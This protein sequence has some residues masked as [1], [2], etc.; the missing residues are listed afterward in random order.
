MQSK[1]L[2]ITAA[3]TLS[4]VLSQAQAQTLPPPPVSPVPVVNFEY[5]AQGNPTRSVAAPSVPA[6]NLQTTT[7][8]D[9]LD[10]PVE[11]TDPR[12]GKTQL[13][14]NGQDRLTQVTDPRNLVTQTPRDGLGNPLKL[15]SPDTG[16]AVHTFDLNGNLATRID[17]RGVK[18]VYT[19]DVLD[20]LTQTVYSQTGQTSL[21][22]TQTYDQTGAGY[23][24]GIG[25]LTSTNSP[26]A[27]SQYLYNE[28][29]WVITE[30]QR[31]KANAAANPAQISKT[32]VYTY[33]GAGVIT[34]ITYPSGRKLSINTVQG[35][36]QSLSLSNTTAAAAAT[37]IL[38]GIQWEPFGPPSNW[39]WPTATGAQPNP[40]IYDLSGRMVRYRLANTVRD[41]TYD[42]AN[43]IT[44][45][46]HYNAT[47]AAPD[48]ALDQT[49][50][51]DAS[52]QLTNITTA[53]ASWSI[54]YDQSGNRTGVT[55]NGQTSLYTIPAT[56]NKLTATTSPAT[57][58]TQ[59]AAGNTTSD[60]GRAYTAVYDL[61]GR[62]ATITKA[63]VTT[64]YSH[65][66]FGRRIRKYSTVG[67]TSTVV[68]IYD[69]AGQLL[70]EYDST[71][72]PLR[73][74]I[75]LGTTPVAMFTP[76]PANTAAGA[77]PLIYTIHA[78][79]LDTPRVVTD[80]N[81]K[82]RWRHIAE[83][84]GTTAPETNPEGLGVFTQNLRFPGQYFDQE[85]GLNYNWHRDYDASI[86]R[87]TESDPI[88]L[89]GGTNTYSYVGGNPLLGYDP[90]GLANSA[91][92]GWMRPKDQNSAPKSC[93]CKDTTQG[94]YGQFG[95]GA[96]VHA[97]LL[98]LSGSVSGAA[99]TSG[100]VCVIRT[101]C[102][103]FGPGIY[104]GAGGSIGGGAVFG[105][106]DSLG[107]WSVG[108]GADA[109][110]GPSIGGQATVGLNPDGSVSSAGAAK[111]KG[112]GGFGASAGL[113]ICYSW[114]DCTKCE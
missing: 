37:P 6:L 4:T 76:D 98:G 43:R 27:S 55:L 28:L 82:I 48:P 79:H 109:G 80:K 71:G 64:T 87:Y 74:Y 69:Q 34:S 86:G 111:G 8:Y 9:R 24:Y 5:D 101:V 29:G 54:T 78:D 90:T 110:Y 45:Y 23:A 33:D 2:L 60:T 70:G 49:F 59:D 39:Q 17:S 93:S 19:V 36:A 92:V 77:P 83:P 20:R 62:L 112:G 107:G 61:S 66:N 94:A 68:F 108:G 114:A 32:V 97:V 47:T 56:S 38:T 91:A 14:R 42:A 104:A 84:F 18:A 113:D 25:R 105:S 26:A 12:L 11:Q 88:G 7:T 44:K 103:R 106:T 50:Q 21:S 46:T 100:Q 57:N 51:Y 75:W 73:E 15:I 67:P 99:S 13:Q 85:S 52:G 95:G 40:K 1:H 16:T 63:G 96:S 30:T 35:V 41:L 53:S 10:R 81:G 3:L 31:I 72:K 65:D 89:G 22:Y 102:G 58:Y